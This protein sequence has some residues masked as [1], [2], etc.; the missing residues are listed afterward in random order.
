M[1][2]HWFVDVMA[3]LEKF[4]DC[5]ICS[6]WRRRFTF[7]RQATICYLHLDYHVGTILIQYW[8]LDVFD[9]CQKVIVSSPS[10]FFLLSRQWCRRMTNQ[11]H[12]YCGSSLLWG[13][14]VLFI[15]FRKTLS[16]SLLLCNSISD[17]C[18]SHV[19]FAPKNNSIC[20][21]WF[22]DILK[23]LFIHLLCFVLLCNISAC[24]LLLF[25]TCLVSGF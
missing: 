25:M 13:S 21:P 16:F 12:I 2:F 4:N 1:C 22:C 18:H 15:F 23:Q 17:K 14:F 3:S 8:W 20:C 5:S 9:Q 6:L 24:F 7:S 10:P 19:L 11:L